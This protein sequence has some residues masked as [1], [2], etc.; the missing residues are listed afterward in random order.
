MVQSYG[1]QAAINSNTS[2]YVTDDSPVNEA[3]YR[4]SF[5]FNPN[6]ISMS[7]GNAHYLLYGMTGSGE[8]TVRVEFGKTK[9]SYRIRAGLSNNSTTW[10]DTS[11]FNISD[12]AHYIEIDW[13]AATASGATDGGLTLW[14]DGVQNANLTGINNDTRRIETVLLG[15]VAGID[16]GTRGLEFFDAFESNR[17]T[18]TPT[19]T[20]TPTDTPTPTAI[21][22]PTPTSTPTNTP[23]PTATF[24]PTPTSTPT[25]TPT[26]MPDLIFADGFETGNFSTWSSSATNNGALSVSTA[27]TMVQLYGMQAAISSNTSIYVTDNSP[28]NEA[29]YRARFYFNPNSISMAKGNSHYLLYGLNGNGVEVLRVEFGWSGTSYRVRAGLSRNNSSWTDSSWFNISNAVH[30]IEIDWRAATASGATDGGLTLWIDGIQNANLTG[31][32]NDTRRIETVLL[33]AVAGIDSGTSGTYYF[34]AY[35]SRRS[36]YIGP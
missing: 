14:I 27:A 12:A 32:S 26:P 6:S 5:Y 10:T 24:T 15:A 36:T 35:E 23:T 19:P 9:T 22:T 30:Y 17:S 16:T 25:L 3:L 31:I 21:F 34:D 1:M 13:R 2:I 29:R 20:S 18:S 11:W 28:V 4:A 7:N 33:G 8:V